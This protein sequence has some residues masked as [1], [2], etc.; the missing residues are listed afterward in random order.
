M[1]KTILCLLSGTFLSFQVSAGLSDALLAYNYQQYPAAAAE[2]TYLQ[3]EGDPVAAY[4]LGRMYQL[5]QGLPV[6]LNQAMALYQMADAAYYFP[7]SAELGKLLVEHGDIQNGIRLLHVAALAG[8]STAVAELANIYLQGNG[9][10]ANPATAFKFYQIA[11]LNGDMKAQYQIAKMY[12]NGQGV[13]QDYTSARK[14][15]SRSANQG[16]VL[17]QIDLAE[18]YANDP[19]LKNPALAYQWYSIIAAYNSDEIG[20]KAAEKRDILLHGKKQKGF[21]KKKIGEIQANIGKWRVKTPQQS[22]PQEERENVQL[23]AIDGFNDP[24]SLQA[25]ISEMGFLP[26]SGEPFGVTTQMVD[27]TIASQNVQTLL[28]TI[29]KAQSRTN[30]AYGYLGDLFKTRL[31]NLTEAFLWYQKGAEAGDVYA[32]Y[33]VARMFCEGEGISQPDAASCYAWLLNVQK[34]QDPVLNGLAQVAISVVQANATPDELTRGQ[35][36][37]TQ[38]KGQT[39]SQENKGQKKKGGFL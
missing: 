37:S 23:Q 1:K 14:W 30:E 3:E 19:L 27:E 28:E 15:L 5:G 35:T 6:D 34:A 16:Y 31:N 7:A 4:Y 24:K 32:Q 9:V 38:L 18:L 11:A 26:R 29:E 22:V 39:A 33:Q 21:D 36:M 13:P 12:F 25:I 2:F 17:A 10:E 8:E 20:R